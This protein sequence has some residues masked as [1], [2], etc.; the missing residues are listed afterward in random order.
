MDFVTCHDGKTLADL[1]MYERKH[2]EANGE[3]NRDGTGDDRAANYGVEGPTDDPAVNAVRARQR[4]NML[5]TLLLSQGVT[6]L[7][8]GDELGRTQRGNNNAYCQDNEV[9]WYDWPDRADPFT[10]FV[11]RVVALQRAHPALKRR[12]FLSGSGA[13]PD[14]AWYDRDGRVMTVGRWQDPATRFLGMLLAGDGIPSR[15]A[16]I[17]DDD[18]LVLLNADTSPADFTVPGRPGARYGLVLDTGAEDGAPAPG[19]ELSVGDR[20]PV[21]PRTVLVA[22][23]PLRS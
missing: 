15:G 2:N 11:R 19:A 20:H 13:P 16:P 23:A 18:I 6:M 14:V 5:A 9:S 21:P 12:A 3:D 1:V 22:T 10:A 4:R 7:L 17:R 8:G